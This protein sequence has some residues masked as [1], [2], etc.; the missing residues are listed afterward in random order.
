M[1]STLLVALLA[2]TAPA[3]PPRS[4][5]FVGEIVSIDVPNRQVVVVQGIKAG[6]KAGPKKRE[7]LAVHVPFTARVLRGTKA[8]SLDEV[9]PRDHAVV[10]YRVAG[11]TAEAFS[12][13]VA[14]L[15]AP[16]PAATPTLPAAGSTGSGGSGGS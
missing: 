2:A 11:G 15:A 1:L 5:T 14:D 9:K 12:L 3:T 13:Q 4:H 10:R 16:E 6:N 8:A 7:T